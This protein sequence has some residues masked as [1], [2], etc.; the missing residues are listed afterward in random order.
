MQWKRNPYGTDVLVAVSKDGDIIHEYGKYVHLFDDTHLA[1]VY[2]PAPERAV[3]PSKK[4]AQLWIEV[5]SRL[6]RT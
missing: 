3:F 2:T 6:T 5:T 1:I 4:E